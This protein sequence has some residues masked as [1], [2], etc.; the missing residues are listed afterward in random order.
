MIE[1]FRHKGLRR[2][3]EEGDRSG[4]NS[5]HIQKIKTI[6]SMLEAAESPE[7]MNVATFRFHPLTGD[8]KGTYVVT[9]RT[10]RRITFRFDGNHAC[11]V[12][13]EDYH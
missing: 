11:D 4:L 1:S 5:E 8:R 6:L 3:Y 12:N 2:L 10:N 13:L 9:V 7:E